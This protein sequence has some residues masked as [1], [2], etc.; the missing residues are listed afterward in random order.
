MP[1]TCISW[2][3]LVG[4]ED[5][6]PKF[7]QAPKVFTF[8]WWICMWKSIFKV[9]TVHKSASTFCLA[10]SGILCA[11]P[12]ARDLW[13]AYT[14]LCFVHYQAYSLQFLHSL[15]LA[16]AE[17]AFWGEYLLISLPTIAGSLT[18]LHILRF[19]IHIMNL[20]HSSVSL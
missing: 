2:W 3:S 4:S 1:C 13:W 19:L 18:C 16:S 15:L 8:N 12:V 7:P 14:V 5:I 6:M 9:Q 11:L 10:L 20:F 17:T